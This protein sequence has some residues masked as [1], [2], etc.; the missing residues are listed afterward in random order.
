MKELTYYVTKDGIM[1]QAIL[2]AG[3]SGEHLATKILFNLSNELSCADEYYLYITNAAGEFYS[4]D[5]L[6]F[7]NN[8]VSYWLPNF[9]TAMSGICKLQLVLKQDQMVLFT[10]PCEIKILPSAEATSGAI[11][12][13]SEISDALSICRSSAKL[14]AETIKRVNDNSAE[15]NRI[16]GDIETALDEIIAL[17]QYYMGGE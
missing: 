10:F 15:H 9:V 1:P 8:S 13:L 14:A 16:V 7:V 3:F 6:D 12:Y 11:N 17:Q 4:T 2:D 5:S